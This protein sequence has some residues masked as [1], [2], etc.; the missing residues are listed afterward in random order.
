MQLAK[1]ADP[2]GVRTVG[3]LTKADLVKEEAVVQT[4]LKLVKGNTLKL[5]YY[6]VRNRGADEDALSIAECQMKE[7]EMFAKLRWTEL[8]KLGRTGVEALRAEL[9][10]LLTEVA[11]RE[12][13]KQKL[14]VEQWLSEC[15]GKLDSMGPPRDSSAGQRECLVR[16]AS[17]F[18][19]IVRDALDGRYEGNPIFSKHGEL[20]LATEMRDLNEGFAALMLRKGHSWEFAEKFGGKRLEIALEYENKAIDIQSSVSSIPELQHLAGDNLEYH[21]PSSESIMGHIEKSYKESRGPELGT[22]RAARS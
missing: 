9:Q 22:V 11:R 10:I 16:L 7:K 15:C 17:Q 5:G 13:P 14:E 19:R 20:K 1:T 3:V 18:E 2:E 12:L 4:L 6:L 8:A 21:S